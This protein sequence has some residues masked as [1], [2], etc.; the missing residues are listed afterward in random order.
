[1]FFNFNFQRAPPFKRP[2]PQ[3]QR[4][5]PPMMAKPLSSRYHHL[6]SKFPFFI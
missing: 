1:M 5:T 3:P 4:P 6:I 2:W